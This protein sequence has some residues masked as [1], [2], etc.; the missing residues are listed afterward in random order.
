MILFFIFNVNFPHTAKAGFPLLV[1][2]TSNIGRSF[3]LCVTFTDN[4][5]GNGIPVTDNNCTSSRKTAK[6]TKYIG[7]VHQSWKSGLIRL[8]FGSFSRSVRHD[9]DTFR[10]SNYIFF[11][12]KSPGPPW[13]LIAGP[14]NTS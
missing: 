14:G 1:Y 13:N 11:V 5:Q 3:D 8:I 6:T 10:L 4:A 12:F 9:R 2:T 7:R